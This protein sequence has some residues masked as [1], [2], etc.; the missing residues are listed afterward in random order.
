MTSSSSPGRGNAPLV[1]DPSTILTNPG[2]ISASTFRGA[3][4]RL[5]EARA[6]VLEELDLVRSG[7]A[8]PRERE[9][10]DA[11]FIDLPERWLADYRA[12]G[13][14]SELG[15]LLIAAERFRRRVDRF[16]VV[17]IGGSYMG[18]RA[19]FE[20]LCRPY[21]NEHTRSE[22]GDRPRV[23]FDGHNVDNDPLHDL[24][25]LLGGADPAAGPDGAWGLVVV[26][27][28]GRTLE[29]ALVFRKL[30]ARLNDACRGDRQRLRDVVL[31][32]T[33]DA[34][35][36]RDIAEALGCDPI[37]S[38][39]ERVGGRYSVLTA[40]GL[41]PAAILGIDVVEMLEGAAAITRRFR[42]EAPG[43][44]P[45][46]DYAGVCHLMEAQRGATIRVLSFW[47]KQLEAFGFWHDQLLSESL[48]KNEK[49]ATPLTVVNTRDLHSRGQQHQ[50]GKRD[51]MLTNVIAERPR[52]A[53][54][55]VG[56]SVTNLDDLDRFQQLTFPDVLLAAVEGVKRAYHGDNR[57]TAD[58][59]VPELN[60]R[61]VGEL[62]QM[63]ML[64]TAVEGHLIGVNPY[65]QPGV[66][67]YK[68]EM[69][70]L[71]RQR[72]GHS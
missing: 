22:R 66:E 14:A 3:F 4:P 37:F 36:L 72:A 65:G 8:I 63:L 16:V 7:R 10:L 60:A 33:G 50:D 48:G 44:N 13:D 5:V 6:R 55:R 12:R 70:A 69:Q 41:L 31:P 59:R 32:V 29:P 21:H 9:P 27:K 34:G 42:D 68:N 39:P 15:R 71:L 45:V 47:G 52:F 2:G 61:S 17:G 19:L 40:A 38:V 46:L 43:E 11:E 53:P 57:P 26:S 54:E 51:K 58:I 23:Y 25:D 28:S 64:A 20:A 49:G 30:V 62:L 24:L 1:Y 67:A 18:T 56:T 35:A